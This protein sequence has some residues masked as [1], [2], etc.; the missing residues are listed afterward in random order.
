[1]PGPYP[2]AP[3]AP[4]APTLEGDDHF[5]GWNCKLP[6]WQLPPGYY[7]WGENKRCA[8]GT[9]RDRDGT[10]TPV[11]ANNFAASSVLGS[12]PF[13]NV[14]GREMCL[15]AT[16]LKVVAIRSGAIPLTINVDTLPVGNIEFS[17]H[18][19]KSLMTSDDSTFAPLAWDGL[20]ADG[21]VALDQSLVDAGTGINALPNVPCAIN[22]LGRTWF[23]LPD[24]P[25]WFAASFVN[26]FTIYD[27][28]YAKFRASTLAGDLRIVGLYP[29]R[30]QT[31]LIIAKRRGLDLMGPIPG[32]LGSTYIKTVA[33]FLGGALISPAGSPPAPI[34]PIPGPAGIGMVARKAGLWVGRKNAYGTLIDDFHF[35]TDFGAGGIYRASATSGELTIDPVPVSDAIAPFFERVNWAA[36]SGSCANSDG[37]YAYWGLPIDGS[38]TNNA[39]VVY[40]MATEQ[41]MGVDLWSSRSN[42]GRKWRTQYQIPNALRLDNLVGFDFYGRRR[43]F[44]IDNATPAV[45]LMYE[46]RED[47]LAPANKTG[48]ERQTWPIAS[49]VETRGYATVGASGNL[50]R[51]MSA[52]QMVLSTYDCDYTI[53]QIMEGVGAEEE[54]ASFSPD[55]TRI[56]GVG[57]G[58]YQVNNAKNDFLAPGRE[59]YAIRAGDGFEVMGT[60]PPDTTVPVALEVEAERLESLS[61]SRS[62]RYVS[63]RLANNAG[64]VAL[65]ETIVESEP[66]VREGR[67]G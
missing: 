27:S 45:R 50:E 62:G 40:N 11:F 19:G 28:I 59:D 23:A 53:T 13:A 26:D 36:A 46:G 42:P 57:K 38:P 63:Y 16:P 30:V 32:D 29:Y 65:L 18:F 61:L 41:W 44:A 52:L 43:I 25:G 64:N 10:Q 37:L 39:V 34:T 54:V 51:T 3:P 22:Y 15:L 35:L 7:A 2:L 8:D 21:F 49:V 6:R 55:R 12:G 9:V 48:T 24:E 58:T 31:G 47:K 14:H 33:A 4:A 1:M 66:A 67:K 5:I 20:S 17:S 56:D 60:N